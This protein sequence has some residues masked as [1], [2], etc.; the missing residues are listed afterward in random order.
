MPFDFFGCAQRIITQHQLVMVVALRNIELLLGG[1]EV[2]QGS[3]VEL[4]RPI[5]LLRLVEKIQCPVIVRSEI[6]AVIREF[7][8]R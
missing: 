2:S 8:F 3:L 6:D 4:Q 5:V 7:I 1:V